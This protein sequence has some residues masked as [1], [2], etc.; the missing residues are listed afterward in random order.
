[1]FM[2]LTFLWS[3]PSDHIQQFFEKFLRKFV[4]L[5]YLFDIF[6]KEMLRRSPPP[7]KPQNGKNWCFSCFLSPKL[8]KSCQLHEKMSFHH[9]YTINFE[10]LNFRILCDR[11]LSPVSGVGRT[12]FPDKFSIPI[13]IRILQFW[14]FLQTVF[15]K[16]FTKLISKN[17]QRDFLISGP[18]FAIFFFY[19]YKNFRAPQTR[20]SGSAD[21]G[22][23]A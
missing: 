6:F 2:T 3:W 8:V 7:V 5:K 4:N 12:G 10:F 17:I 18:I 11:W 15:C 22:N 21:T 13:S 20:K 19:K 14:R 1:M 9:T 16:L 23:W